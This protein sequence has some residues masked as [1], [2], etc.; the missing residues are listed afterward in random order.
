MPG[1]VPEARAPGQLAVVF[2]AP[3]GAH[4]DHPHRQG[5]L[6]LLAHNHGESQELHC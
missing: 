2:V 1:L 6:P 4:Q 5:V 3:R